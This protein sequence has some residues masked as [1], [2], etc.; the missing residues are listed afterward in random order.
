MLKRN[1]IYNEISSLCILYYSIDE[2]TIAIG[3]RSLP[4]LGR[5]SVSYPRTLPEEGIHR[6]LFREQGQAASLLKCVFEIIINH[7]ECP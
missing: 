5:A 7:F 6:L 3:F 4:F 2:I 1:Y